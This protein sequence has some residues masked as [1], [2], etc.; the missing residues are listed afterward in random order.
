MA[1]NKNRDRKRPQ[2]ERTSPS[3]RPSAGE[4]PEPDAQAAALIP[5]E[6]APRGK[7]QKRFGHN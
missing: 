5:G 2:A 4:S 1:K 6:S 7:R 3:A